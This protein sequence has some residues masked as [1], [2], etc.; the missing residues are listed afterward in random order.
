[1]LCLKVKVDTNDADYMTHE[2]RIT[3]EMVERL[4]PLF[5]AIKDFKPYKTK[6]KYGLN[7]W[8][9]RHNYPFGECLREDMGEKSPKEIYSNIDP[10]L[11]EIF[12]EDYIPYPRYG[13]HTIVSIDL[14]QT[15]TLKTFLGGKSDKKA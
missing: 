6:T 11:I 8:Q 12:E 5:K 13:F 15:E 2:K 3:P 1:M 9:Y 10:E 4:K 14:I 7:D